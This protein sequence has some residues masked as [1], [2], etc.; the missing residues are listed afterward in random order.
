MAITFTGAYKDMGKASSAGTGGGR[1]N[2]PKDGTGLFLLKTACKKVNQDEVNFR[3]LFDLVSVED[4]VDGAYKKGDE[5]QVCIHRSK[6]K[7]DAGIF[8]HVGEL[9]AWI[10]AMFGVT[11]G[12]DALI[13]EQGA[14][15]F[16]PAEFA[17]LDETHQHMAAWMGVTRAVLGQDDSD[18]PSGDPGCFDG[19]AVLRINFNT[20]EPHAYKDGSKNEDGTPKMTKAKQHTNHRGRVPVASFIE[21]LTEAE[22]IQFFGSTD[23]VEK[24][25]E[26]EETEL[27]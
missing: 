22:M 2:E 18:E 4:S 19:Q 7:D 1:G 21:E 6:Y 24:L 14:E 8:R 13:V 10:A 26:A 12:N 9:K 23:A 25:M 17:E 27:G 15:L 3:Y 11:D 16:D 20:Q 5:I